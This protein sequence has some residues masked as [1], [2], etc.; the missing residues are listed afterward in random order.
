MTQEI[1]FQPI[2]DYI[3]EKHSEITERFDRLENRV[4]KLQESVDSL[5]KIVKDFR[6]EHIILH[7]RLETLEAWAKQVAKQT[8]IPLPV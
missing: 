1:N 5:A 2:F 6:D 3:D 7:R 8:G 4:D